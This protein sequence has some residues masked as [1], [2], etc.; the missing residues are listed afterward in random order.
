MKNKGKLEDAVIKA[1]ANWRKQCGSDGSTAENRH[2]AFTAWKKAEIIR[3][4]ALLVWKSENS[5]R[6]KTNAERRKQVV[7][8]DFLEAGTDRRR[9]AR[10]P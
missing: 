1:R 2:K 6:R 9:Q 10:R 3:N 8:T 5:N 7:S 4:K